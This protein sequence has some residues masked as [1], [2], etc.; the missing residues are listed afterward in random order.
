V[1]PLIPYQSVEAHCADELLEIVRDSNFYQWESV[2]SVLNDTSPRPK[3][4][5]E[6]IRET[7]HM[8]WKIIA[9]KCKLE[10][11]PHDLQDLINYE[12][13]QTAALSLESRALMVR[14]GTKMTVSTLIRLCARHSVWH[15]GQIALS[16]WD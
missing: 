10:A 8:Y 13:A 1:F 14:Y 2:S 7:K 16:R 4:L 12:L 3:R 9:K 6:H 5:L 11:P 15:A